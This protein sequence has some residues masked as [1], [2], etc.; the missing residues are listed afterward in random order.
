MQ[1][2]AAVAKDTQAAFGTPAITE[3]EIRSV[4]ELEPISEPEE[5]AGAA[6]TDPLTGEPIEQPTKTGQPDN[7][8]Q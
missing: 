4:G 3:N 7:P 5:P 2:L 6:T 8:A 1:A